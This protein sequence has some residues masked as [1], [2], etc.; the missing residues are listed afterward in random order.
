M[1][2][3]C[4]ETRL[5][6]RLVPSGFQPVNLNFNPLI[7]DRSQRFQNRVGLDEL[8]VCNDPEVFDAL[9]AHFP[10]L[11]DHPLD[12]NGSFIDDARSLGKLQ[13]PDL[14][15]FVMAYELER[16][17]YPSDFPFLT[18]EQNRQLCC[19]QDLRPVIPWPQPL[20]TLVQRADG[21][22]VTGNIRKVTVV[23]KNAG[24]AQVWFGGD[25]AVLWEAYFDRQ[26]Q[27]RDDHAILMT[28]LWGVLE[29]YLQR[30]GV[31]QVYTYAS[32]PAFE[33]D[34]YQPWLEARGYRVA[35]ESPRRA[36]RKELRIH[37]QAQL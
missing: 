29:A 25:T 11:K 9:Y 6:R 4:L 16:E 10:F 26:L 34:W 27:A 21:Q 14:L 8:L 18:A 5:G 31:T 37:G 1:C 33:D 28:Q 17:P 3:G 30:V 15:G 23:L 13:R 36:M 22:L 24:N 7:K 32:D 19:H 35:D 12:L 2:L 20:T